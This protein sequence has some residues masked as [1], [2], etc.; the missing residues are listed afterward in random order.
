MTG[1]FDSGVGGLISYREVRRI[2]P[3]EDIAY[4]ADRGGAPYGTKTKEQ[5]TELVG[6]DLERLRRLGAKRILVACCTASTVIPSLPKELLRGVVTVIEP[7]AEIAAGG[8]KIAVIATEYTAASGAFGKEISR[9][10]SRAE[11]TEIAAQP[12]VAFVESG[13]RDGRMNADCREY[14]D[15]LSEKIRNLKADTLILGCTHFSHLSG[16]LRA[17]LHGV[18]L[19]SPAIEGAAKLCKEIRREPP[20]TARGKNSYTEGKKFGKI[21]A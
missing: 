11:V 1:I 4:L 9:L 13:S 17:R 16:E 10:N 19:I 21:R 8:N 20:H 12:L 3:R 7:A 6:C 18:R 2:L 15:T 14:L 5:L